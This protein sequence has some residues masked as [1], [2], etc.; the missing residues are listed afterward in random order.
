MSGKSEWP[1]WQIMR[2]NPAAVSCCPAGSSEKSCWEIVEQ[3]DIYAA[4]VCQD[5]LVK[6]LNSGQT[7]LSNDE[8]EIIMKKKAQEEVKP[9]ANNAC[10]LCHCS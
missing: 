3:L 1:C 8:I 2:C 9:G 6:V 5:C 4:N 10:P 7:K